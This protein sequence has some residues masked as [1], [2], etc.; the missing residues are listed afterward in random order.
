[1]QAKQHQQLR[2]GAG[3]GGWGGAGG[4]G[5][6]GAGTDA[7]DGDAGLQA[8]AFDEAESHRSFLDA[9]NEWRAANRRAQ[10]PAQSAEGDD[11]EEINIV[12]TSSRQDAA[13]VQTEAAAPLAQRAGSA[14]GASSAAAPTFFDR[15]VIN[16][17]A[18]QAGQMA[19]GS[20]GEQGAEGD[21]QGGARGV[22]EGGADA[23]QQRS[24]GEGALRHRGLDVLDELERLEE[25][26]RQRAA[27]ASDSEEEW[28]GGA[29]A[30]ASTA[31]ERG[32]AGAGPVIVTAHGMVGL[33][34]GARLPD[35]ILLPQADDSGGGE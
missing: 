20:A 35:A 24:A 28:A 3:W 10:Q 32:A 21:D 18:R 13:E 17:T 2:P 6:G 8:G 33:T 29:G 25:Q 19:S 4:G 30:D 15:L 34:K 23:Q 31:H 27:E 9:L 16:S 5:V 14:R 11:Q 22:A 12:G 7:G 1:M 26:Q